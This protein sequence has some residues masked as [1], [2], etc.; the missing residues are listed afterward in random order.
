VTSKAGIA[1]GEWTQR[2]GNEVPMY[3]G[4]F[5]GTLQVVR[6]M[7]GCHATEKYDYSAGLGDRKDSGRA[8]QPFP[9]QG[10]GAYAES[11]GEGGSG[12]IVYETSCANG[13]CSA[14]M[15]LHPPPP[16]HVTFD[17]RGGSTVVVEVFS[18]GYIDDGGCDNGQPYSYAEVMVG[19]GEL[20]L[21]SI[22][23]KAITVSIGRD[24]SLPEGHYTGS[25][26]VT[27]QRVN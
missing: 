6:G 2:T 11:F 18:S 3:K 15:H 16:G 9:F 24:D 27:L 13:G 14:T 1:A 17:W 4:Q 12:S 26:S 20:P 22:G 19:H 5:S 7:A 25:G 23:D 8:G 10:G 21:D